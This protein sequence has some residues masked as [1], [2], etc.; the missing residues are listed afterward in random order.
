MPA[1]PRWDWSTSS[2][3]LT[4]ELHSY[5]TQ[6]AN[7]RHGAG[8]ASLDIHAWLMTAALVFLLHDEQPFRFVGLGQPTAHP[9]V[10]PA[11][12]PG[13]IVN[14]VDPGSRASRCPG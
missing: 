9:H 1:P 5:A 8:M 2:D 13:S 7:P 11:S 6:R 3:M 14:A 12:E 10:T 4:R